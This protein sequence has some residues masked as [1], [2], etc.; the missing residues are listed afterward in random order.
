MR[1]VRHTVA[2]F[3]AGGTARAWVVESLVKRHGFTVYRPH[4]GGVLLEHPMGA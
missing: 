4:R 3:K 2:A 1:R